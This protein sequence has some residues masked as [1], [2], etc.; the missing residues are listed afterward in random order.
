MSV[1]S[2]VSTQLLIALFPPYNFYR[3]FEGRDREKISIVH[4]VQSLDLLQEVCRKDLQLSNQN[5]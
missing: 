1:I 4:L 2:T 3:V 5:V